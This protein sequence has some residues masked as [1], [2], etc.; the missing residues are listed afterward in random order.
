MFNVF[1]PFF[2]FRSICAA[3]LLI[4]VT[5]EGYIYPDTFKY[6]RDGLEKPDLCAD[7]PELRN[8]SVASD[9]SLAPL[10]NYE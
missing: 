2:D 5:C 3:I 10:I 7:H 6:K 4:N 8:M 9:Y 1:C